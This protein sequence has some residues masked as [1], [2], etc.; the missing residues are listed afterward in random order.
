MFQ[1]RN[2]TI[3]TFPPTFR[4]LQTL[5][6]MYPYAPQNDDELELMQGDFIFMS[7]V[8]QSSA[9]EGW[10]YGTSLGTG[11]SG[12]LPENYVTRADESDTWVVHGWGG[13]VARWQSICWIVSVFFPVVLPQSLASPGF[14][15][16]SVV[17]EPCRS[18]A[19]FCDGSGVVS[20]NVRSHSVL[21]CA[22]PSNSG[23][24]VGGL[25]F[26]GKLSDSLLDSL[27]DPSTH[28]GLCPPMQ[29]QFEFCF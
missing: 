24:I 2:W 14:L 26:D 19:V 22:S 1:N 7:P 27:M 20:A 16:P 11:L 15:S 10:V 9:S 12:L 25:L 4:L 13:N 5:Q 21:N 3:L 29:V 23:G 8:E 18:L 6:V 28:T 17:R